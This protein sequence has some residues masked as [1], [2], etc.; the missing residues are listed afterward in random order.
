MRLE[1]ETLK[2]NSRDTEMALVECRQH[3]V[4]LN[5]RVAELERAL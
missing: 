1:I 2:I 4:R 5:A 3:E